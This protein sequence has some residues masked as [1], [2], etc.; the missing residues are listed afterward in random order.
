MKLVLRLTAK[1]ILVPL[2]SMALRR[3]TSCVMLALIQSIESAAK[4]TI[5]CSLHELPP[6]LFLVFSPSDIV[7][8]KWFGCCVGFFVV[9]EWYG[10]RL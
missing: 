8:G 2:C 10:S 6:L 5:S 9:L 1:S 3:Y 4:P 7:R